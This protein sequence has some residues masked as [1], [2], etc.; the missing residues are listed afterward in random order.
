MTTHRYPKNVLRSD[1]LR[2][3]AG[4]SICLTLAIVTWGTS[5]GMWLFLFLT[6]LFAAFA[7]RTWWRAATEYRLT[8]AGLLRTNAGPAGRSATEVLWENLD[9]LTLRFYPLRRDR[10]E[11]WMQL[12][13]CAPG[14]RLSIDSTLGDFDAVA[15][16]A[17]SA[18]L[19]NELPM[20]TATLA[21]F[22]AIGIE[23]PRLPESAPPPSPKAPRGLGK[24]SAGD[25]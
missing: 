25:Q 2:A 7:V 23:P 3:A 11:G 19:R 24:T 5:F 17:L 14:A 1:Y 9:G 15:R 22:Q 20:T 13:I 8:D 16:S 10:S 6:A 4:F 21:N 12:T 18:G